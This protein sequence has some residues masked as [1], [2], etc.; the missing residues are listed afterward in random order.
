MSDKKFDLI[1]QE[2]KI[3]KQDQQEMKQDQQE[4]K[5]NQLEMKQEQQEIKQEQQQMKNTFTERFDVLEQK[6][7][8]IQDQVA[9]NAENIT[10]MQTDVKDIKDMQ[11]IMIGIQERQEKT[12]DLLARRSIDQEAELKRVRLS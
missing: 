2:L 6:V 7:D 3:I 9:K 12:I 8:G 4:M 10:V 1:L 11:Q 5:Q